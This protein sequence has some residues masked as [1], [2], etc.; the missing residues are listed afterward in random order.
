MVRR[1]VF[2]QI[3]VGQERVSLDALQEALKKPSVAKLV[4]G[5]APPYG[6]NL[7]EV[8]YARGVAEEKDLSL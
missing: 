4:P 1:M 2:V 3:M 8:Q 7:K 6:L 5:L